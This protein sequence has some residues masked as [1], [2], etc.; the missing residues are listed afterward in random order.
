MAIQEKSKN[1][2]ADKIKF[3]DTTLNAGSYEGS[4]NNRGSNHNAPTQA[5]ETSA[6][7]KGWSRSDEDADMPD[8]ETVG[9]G[10]GRPTS[11]YYNE[12]AEKPE[13]RTNASEE[14]RNFEKPETE[15]QIESEVT[16]NLQDRAPSDAGGFFR[17]HSRIYGSRRSPRARICIASQRSSGDCD[18]KNLGNNPRKSCSLFTHWTWRRLFSGNVAFEE[19]LK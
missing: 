13:V 8:L 2:D 1:Q 7:G 6:S 15:S 18:K 10:S 16:E 5:S 14:A 19:T 11:T 12:T 3:T 17:S 9:Y 4:V